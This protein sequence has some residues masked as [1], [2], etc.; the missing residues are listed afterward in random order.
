VSWKIRSNEEIDLLIKHT[1]IVIYIKA[2][3]IR[4]IEYIVKMDTERTVTIMIT[5]WRPVAIRRIGRTRLRWEEDV[6]KK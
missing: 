5:E 3:R 4:W 2:Q 1:D 6:W